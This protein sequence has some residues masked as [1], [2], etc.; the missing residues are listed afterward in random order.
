MEDLDTKRC[1]STLC[2]SKDRR[3]NSSLFNTEE[4]WWQ[5][6]VSHWIQ[7]TEHFAKDENIIW[8]PSPRANA[9]ISQQVS[10]RNPRGLVGE[11]KNRDVGSHT[12]QFILPH[13]ICLLW[14]KFEISSPDMW[15]FTL[16]S[17]SMLAHLFWG[18]LAPASDSSWKC[19]GW[20]GQQCTL[21]SATLQVKAHIKCPAYCLASVPTKSAVITWFTSLQRP[22]WF[23]QEPRSQSYC[24]DRIP[25]LVCIFQAVRAPVEHLFFL[26][27]QSIM[28]IFIT[29][30]TD[31]ILVPASHDETNTYN[32]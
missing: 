2:S 23:L 6:W 21:I 26:A 16:C 5:Y 4:T 8:S 32:L 20:T 30:L 25:W 13:C 9:I 29:P 18:S 22:P 3:K 14:I 24:W 31:Q 12:A 10:I 11:D 17:F 1:K 19:S 27:F 28:F 7:E 15:H